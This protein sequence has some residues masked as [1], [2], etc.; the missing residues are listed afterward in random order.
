MFTKFGSHLTSLTRSC[1]RYSLP[2][3]SKRSG[4]L[5]AIAL[6]VFFGVFA[7]SSKAGSLYD[8]F[9]GNQAVGKDLVGTPILFSAPTTTQL[10]PSGSFNVPLSVDD[11]TGQGIISF[12]FVLTYDPTVI[13]ASGANPC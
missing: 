7:Q 11:V 1:K 6:L 2:Y 13:V 9:Y 3:L 5:I 12:Q 8:F 4:S 10:T